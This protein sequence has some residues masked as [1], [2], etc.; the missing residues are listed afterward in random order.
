MR[1][2]ARA[3]PAAPRRP[4]RRR[5]VACEPRHGRQA[6]ADED[7]EA[8]LAVAQHADERDA[9]DL[10]GVAAVRAGGD[11]DLV[12]ARQVG[13]VRVAVEEPRHLVEDGRHVEE[14][15]GGDACDRA[16][17]HVAHRVAARTD[18]RQPDLVEP[19]KDLGQGCELEIVELDRLARRQLARALAVLERELPHC[20]QLLGRDPAGG[21]LDAEHERP[22]L[23]LVVVEAPPLEADEILLGCLLVAGGDQ[24]GQ[25]VEHAERALLTLDALDRVPLQD[26]LER[27]RPLLRP[28][29]PR[30][31]GCHYFNLYSNGALHSQAVRFAPSGYCF[32]LE[33]NGEPPR[34]RLRLGL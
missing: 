9:V 28:A 21:Q 14:L 24:R 8:G 7:R 11:R 13:V 4:G 20:A 3:G 25:L 1:R 19:A 6:A 34:S 10:G 12:L 5:R 33:S 18:G 32:T 31:L 29:C 30:P 15:V 22:D 2:G 17:R 23:R 26:E 16:A 27:G